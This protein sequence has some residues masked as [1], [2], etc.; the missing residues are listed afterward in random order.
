M[1]LLFRRRQE[2]QERRVN[3]T[4]R[5]EILARS[6]SPDGSTCLTSNIRRAPIRRAS[7]TARLSA[8]T[9]HEQGTCLLRRAPFGRRPD[10][11]LASRRTRRIAL[12]NQRAR[13][14]A[15]EACERRPYCS[16]ASSAMWCAALSSKP[17]SAAPVSDCIGERSAARHDYDM[18]GAVRDRG[19]PI[20]Q[21]ARKSVAP[22]ELND[23]SAVARSRIHSV[24]P[25]WVS[26]PR[27]D[28]AVHL[29]HLA[30]RSRLILHATLPGP[31][32]SFST[33]T[34]TLATRGWPRMS[35]AM[36]SAN[37]ST[38]GICSFATTMRM[39]SV[40]TSYE[41]CRRM[42]SGAW[43]GRLIHDIDVEANVLAVSRAR[44]HRRP[45][46]TVSTK[47]R[48]KTRSVAGS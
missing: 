36:R 41:I 35:A 3:G 25:E 12:T 9:S 21:L 43:P 10:R 48:T 27:Q 32:S 40:I 20:A 47:S 5:N 22:T 11:H 46:G 18:T 19:E 4:V 42:S 31:T 39:P 34:V 13:D 30:C 1:T 24:A 45:C 17:I 16:M 7:Q 37:V 8:V 23:R 29:G 15:L 6:R 33:R 26:P 2:A 44:A 28:R 38:R 14:R